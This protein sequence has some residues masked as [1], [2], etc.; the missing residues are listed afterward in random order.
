MKVSS[1][2]RSNPK[3]KSNPIESNNK[4]QPNTQTAPS[5][6]ILFPP[7]APFPSPTWPL[8]HNCGISPCW[9]HNRRFR[10]CPSARPGPASPSPAAAFSISTA[11]CGRLFV[12]VLGSPRIRCELRLAKTRIDRRRRRREWLG[13]GFKNTRVVCR[14]EKWSAIMKWNPSATE[15]VK[16]GETKRRLSFVSLPRCEARQVEAEASRPS[17][18]DSESTNTNNPDVGAV[19]L[20]LSSAGRCSRRINRPDNQTNLATQAAARGML[21]VGYIFLVAN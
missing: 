10:R 7:R 20:V 11:S 6:R 18:P 19:W 15:W 4:S 21:F 14:A 16:L 17:R 3:R 2:P 8:T 1:E 9:S 13:V 5:D 12:G